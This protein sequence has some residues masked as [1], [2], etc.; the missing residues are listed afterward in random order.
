MFR[1]NEAIRLQE[2]L[3]FG[4][5]TGAGRLRLLDEDALP[6]SIKRVLS[7]FDARHAPEI[8]EQSKTLSDG[9]PLTTSGMS[10]PAG[11]QRTVIREALSDLRILDLINTI[12]D[13]TSG[14][15]TTIPYEVRKPGSIVQ[16]GIVYEGAGIPRASIEQKID[17]A[18][19]SAMKLSF[20]I[21]SEMIFFS[22]NSLLDWNALSKNIESNSR[23]VKELLARRI[24]NEMQR[25]ADCFG[26]VG[27]VTDDI[28]SQLTGTASIIKTAYFPI[29][30]P[31][32]V[33]DLQGVQIGDTEHPISLVVNGAVAPAWDGSGNQAAGIYW[34]VENY[35]LGFLRIVDKDGNPITPSATSACSLTYSVATNCATFDLK[36]PSGVAMEDHLNGLLRAVGARKAIMNSDRYVLPDFMIMSPILNDVL[37]NASQFVSSQAR[38]GSELTAAGDLQS[39]KSIPTYSTNAPN[40]D[41]GDDRILMGATGTLTYAVAKPFETG[42]PFDAF[43]SNRLP[44]GE[45]IAYGEEFSAVHIP[46]AL[47][48]RLTSVIVYDSDAR[49]AAH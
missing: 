17:I 28:A 7:I 31:K 13:P 2:T 6:A 45:K 21:S 27:P 16:D 37:T 49:A 43:N 24:L 35:N 15:T 39:I 40:V 32:T 42:Q 4:L 47:R 20:A 14:A 41:L 25:S 5:R 18:Y 10:V 33:R 46:V 11:F 1:K 38:A 23:L 19:L 26:A 3:N 44:T 30:R 34:R 8:L 48:G 12:I 36:L 22:N 29:I 9:G